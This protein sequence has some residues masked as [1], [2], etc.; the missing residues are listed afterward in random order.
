MI[1]TSIVSAVVK[2]LLPAQAVPSCTNR[3]LK[4]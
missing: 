1:P 4:K 2:K 3:M